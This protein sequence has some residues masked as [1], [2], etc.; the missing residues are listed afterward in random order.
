MNRCKAACFCFLVAVVQLLGCQGLKDWQN[1]CSSRSCIQRVFEELDTSVNEGKGYKDYINSDG[2]PTGALLAWSESYLTQAYAEIFRATGDEGYLDKLYDHINSVIRNRDD[3]RGQLDYKGDLVPA[4]GTDRYTRDKAWIHFVV[5]TGM[6]TYPML[7]FVQLIREHG[8]EK[9]KDEAEAILARVRE[10]VDYHDGQWIV[11]ETGFGLYT[12]PEDYYRK[13]NYVIPLDQQAAMGRSLVLLWRLT[14]EE[15]Y[16]MYYEKARDIALAVKASLQQSNVDG[17][18]WGVEIGP[19][20][21]RNRV[22]DI[23]HSTLTV[24]FI[25]LAYEAGLVFNTNDMYQ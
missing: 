21:D 13:P 19:L 3:F 16:E 2:F 12:Y 10:S 6:I 9:L 1:D 20:S 4:W 18:V 25:R 11:Q 17:Y 8:I 22:A 14:G 5:H 15:M 7:E 24:D 23:S